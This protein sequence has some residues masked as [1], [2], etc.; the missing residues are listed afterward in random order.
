MRVRIILLISIVLNVAL[1]ATLLSFWPKRSNTSFVRPVNAAAVASNQPIRI[2]KTNLLVRPRVFTWQEVESGDYVTYV[3]NLRALGMPEATIRDIIIA[4]VDQVFARRRRELASQQDIEW[5]RAQPSQAYTTNQLAQAFALDEERTALLNRLLGEGWKSARVDLQADPVHLSGPILSAL[6]DEV[7]ST[8]QSIAAQSAERVRD[9][10]NQAQA[11]GRQ[12]N[13]LELARLREQTRVEL[14]KVLS[15]EQLEEFLIRNSYNSTQ[16]RQQLAGLDVTPDEF[17]AIFRRVDQIDRDIQLRYSG[18]DAESQRR[19]AALEQE[20]LAAIRSAVGTERFGTFVMQQDPLYQ[21]YLLAAERAGAGADAA[22]ALYEITR[23]T[24]DEVA[25][26]RSDPRL[27][28]GQK[29]EQ[30]R[31]VEAETQRARALV[32]GEEIPEETRAPMMV[33][34]PQLRSHVKGPGE[35]LGQ[36]A[37]RYGLRIPEIREANP[38]VDINRAPAGTVLN[39]PVRVERE[40]PPLPYPPGSR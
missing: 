12:I 17:R 26:I 21:E 39:I 5:W 13:P 7:K 2:V 15:P 6:S 37:F 27:T 16:L 35:T 9:Y 19:R 29:Q 22:A 23:A 28:A 36:L 4:D 25:R 8:V 18:D 11:A 14:A 1:A 24:T 34:E 30:I 33:T 20:R 10:L 32:L 31:E 3:E 38:G 40:L